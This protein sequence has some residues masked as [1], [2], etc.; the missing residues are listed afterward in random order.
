MNREGVEVAA[1]IDGL[2]MKMTCCPRGL[3]LL[4][5]FGD[6]AMPNNLAAN[7]GALE[8]TDSRKGLS[9]L[10]HEIGLA[11]VAIELN[12][13]L[14]A[15]QPDAAEAIERG[16]AAL[17]D[18]GYAPNLIGHRRSVW[19]REKASHQN[20]RRRASK[21]RQPRPFPREEGEIELRH[22]TDG[23]TRSASIAAIP[24]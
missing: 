13:E 24:S 15:L 11:A 16:A 23:I 2:S 3:S 9:S 22:E 1:S 21:A 7:P 5:F 12:L 17:F 18:A 20:V 19:I 10:C 4:F 8:P 6:C 14:S